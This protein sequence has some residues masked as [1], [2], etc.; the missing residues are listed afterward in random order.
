CRPLYEDQDARISILANG[1][2]PKGR[3][4]FRRLL[5]SF[6]ANRLP[7][8]RAIR[9]RR[10]A[11]VRITAANELAVEICP[12]R[13]CVGTARNVEP[14][15]NHTAVELG[16]NIWPNDDQARGELGIFGCNEGPPAVGAKRRRRSIATCGPRQ[17]PLL[18]HV[19]G[20]NTVESP[21]PKRDLPGDRRP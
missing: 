5:R 10:Y 17:E 3:I 9:L 1:N 12:I 13:R 14:L 7:T 19:T 21:L 11:D 15:D 16:S 20:R 2:A 4:R 18:D 6:D 8:G